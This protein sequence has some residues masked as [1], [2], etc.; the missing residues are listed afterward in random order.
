[1]TGSWV[2]ATFIIVKVS[3]F[4]QFWLVIPRYDAESKSYRDTVDRFPAGTTDAEQ[5][6]D[7]GLLGFLSFVRTIAPSGARI[8]ASSPGKPV[9]LS[10]KLGTGGFGVVYYVW[11]AVPA[12]STRLRS[13]RKT[14]A[15]TASGR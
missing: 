8:P 15:K 7:L 12:S 11:N 13:R 4:L 3:H 9:T 1:L 5:L 14:R 10:K 2:G 6:L